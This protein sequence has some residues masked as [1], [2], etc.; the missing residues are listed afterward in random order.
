V[1]F[2]NPDTKLIQMV[3]YQGRENNEVVYKEF[4]AL[5]F[6]SF[7]GIQYPVRSV[8]IANGLQL[9]EWTVTKLERAEHPASFFEQP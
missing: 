8:V 1:V 4:L 9:A 7:Q 3:A 2:L 5:E 6:K